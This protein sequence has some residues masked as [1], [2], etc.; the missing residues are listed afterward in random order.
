M[1]KKLIVFILLVLLFIGFIAYRFMNLDHEA[2]EGMLKIASSP[3]ATVILNTTTVGKTPFEN[4]VA[5]G[6]YLVKLIPEGTASE[7]ATWQ[8]KIL[9][10]KNTL[11]Y[12]DRELGTSDNTSAGVVFSISKMPNKPKLPDTGEIEVDSE[13]NGAIVYLDNDEK[14]ISSLMMSDVPKGEH[15]LSVSLPGYFRRSQKIN[16][17]AGFRMHAEFKLAIDPAYKKINDQPKEAT[18][19]AN[20]TPTISVGPSG[21]LQGSPIPTT[22]ALIQFYVIINDTPTGWLRVRES[23]SLNASETARVDPGVRFPVLETQSG[24]YK[25]EYKPNLTGWIAAQYAKKT[26]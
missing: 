25:I 9:I 10:N 11:T 5:V 18:D 19:S 20:L 1:K 6:E 15:E 22:A 23:P 21:S 8:G 12:I 26:E 4:K 3:N 14:G 16:V 2:N 24:W 17:E 13:P 7:A